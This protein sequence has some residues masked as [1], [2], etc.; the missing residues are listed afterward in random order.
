M[1]NSNQEMGKKLSILQ[2]KQ[3]KSGMNPWSHI[4]NSFKH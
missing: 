4:A 3:K 1:L 2:E